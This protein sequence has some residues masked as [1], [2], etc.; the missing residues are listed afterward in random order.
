MPGVV[1][2]LLGVAVAGAATLATSS[3]HNG[4]GHR[5]AHKVALVRA[6]D[7]PSPETVAVISPANG[8]TGVASDTSIIVSFSAPL[9]TAEPDPTVSPGVPGTWLVRSPTTWVFTPAASFV[10]S[11]TY[12]VTVPGGPFG[13]VARDGE[14][15]TP[16]VSATFTTAAGSVLRLQQLLATL[17]YLPL[18]FTGTTPRPRD[19]AMPQRGT[20]TWRS[21]GLPPQLTGQWS[22]TTPNPLTQGAVMA[23]ET[24][25]GLTVDGVASAQV[26]SALLA[27]AAAGTHDAE[28][29]TYVLV[30]KTLPEH[31]TVWVNGVLTLANVPCNTG[32][33]GAPTTDGTFA[34]FSH[35]QVSNMRGTDVTGTSYDVTVPW[36][37]YFNGGEALHGYPRTSYGY[38]Q[39]NGCV[40]MPIATAGAVWPDTPIGTLVTVQGPTA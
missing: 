6:P 35:E 33:A 25:N 10:P 34:V 39:S 21:D 23:F 22:P 14:V 17:G 20:F 16:A 15:L 8:A 37:S 18:Q 27:D 12:T 2:T 11:T 3:A 38:P 7:P 40:E 29:V 9:R 19:M 4:D 36:A 24:Q 32:V 30:T 5:P 31:L 28:A 13:M 1:V 26:W